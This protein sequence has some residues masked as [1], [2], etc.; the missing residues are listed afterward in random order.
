MNNN[1]IKTIFG[2]FTRLELI[3]K[4]CEKMGFNVSDF[5]NYSNEEL[6]EAYANYVENYYPF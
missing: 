4:I 2:D 5:D 1:V 6:S 3:E